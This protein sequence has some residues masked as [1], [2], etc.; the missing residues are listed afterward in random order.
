MSQLISIL[1]QFLCNFDKI[2]IKA[3]KIHNEEGLNNHFLIFAKSFDE[4]AGSINEFR[5]YEQLMIDSTQKNMIANYIKIRK[6]VLKELQMTNYSGNDI[7]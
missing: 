4:H 7:K 2:N 1:L 3:Q 5:V 6:K